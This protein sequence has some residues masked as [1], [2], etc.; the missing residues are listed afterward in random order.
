M[1]ETVKEN[2]ENGKRVNEKRRDKKEREKKRKGI[3][4]IVKEEKA[5][6]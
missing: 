2:K 1:A 6:E 5:K 4:P 3:T